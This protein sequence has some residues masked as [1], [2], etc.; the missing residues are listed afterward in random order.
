MSDV[1]GGVEMRSDGSSSDG[2]VDISEYLVPRNYA[3]DT[4]DDDSET[5]TAKATGGNRPVESDTKMHMLLEE[6][7]TIQQTYTRLM[8]AFGASEK[9]NTALVLSLQRVTTEQN[10]LAR[11]AATSE[12]AAQARLEDREGSVSSSADQNDAVSDLVARV[13]LLEAENAA[14]RRKVERSPSVSEEVVQTSSHREPGA[15]GGASQL[16]A[17]PPG[18]HEVSVSERGPSTAGVSLNPSP[19]H[20]P[21]GHTN[22]VEYALKPHRSVCDVAVQVALPP[23]AD[24]VAASTSPSEMLGGPPPSFTGVLPPHTASVEF[25]AALD[26]KIWMAVRC[27]SKQLERVSKLLASAEAR[28][29]ELSA[30]LEQ[31]CTNLVRQQE[32]EEH[33]G[34]T[35]APLLEPATSAATSV[36]SGALSGTG[37]SR[38][39]TAA[40]QSVA[41]T[42]VSAPPRAQ[43]AAK[44]APLYRT[45][46]PRIPPPAATI[47]LS[48][49]TSSLRQVS[50]ARA[51][52]SH[53]A[54]GPYLRRTG[55][56]GVYVEKPRFK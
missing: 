9:E 20:S 52:V 10:R 15:S 49:P 24:S 18:F 13:A 28:N 54:S 50:P 56:A 38:S 3:I 43:P 42:N 53:S 44:P 17:S 39:G 25:T 31:L 45:V 33:R 6:L 47:P 48:H 16:I 21:L 2:E 32:L 30:L 37:R 41:S 8:K 5:P 27:R 4:S 35:A 22:H 46:A 14:L 7:E 12:S 40:L 11:N 19:A 51:P 23:A 26:E 1:M 36:R 34:F 55:L 29:V